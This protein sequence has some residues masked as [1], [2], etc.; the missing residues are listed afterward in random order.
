MINHN[1]KFHMLSSDVALLKVFKPKSKYRLHAAAILL[2]Y[3]L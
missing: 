3:S 1:T 2:F